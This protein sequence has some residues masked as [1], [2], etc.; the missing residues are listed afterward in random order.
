[1]GTGE[2]LLIF[3]EEIYIIESNSSS[4]GLV[5]HLTFLSVQEKMSCFFQGFNAPR[6][7]FIEQEKG[8]RTGIGNEG[9]GDKCMFM[10]IIFVE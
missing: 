4:Q 5:Y 9:S 7:E 2:K 3:G 6:G 10:G 8:F 1:L